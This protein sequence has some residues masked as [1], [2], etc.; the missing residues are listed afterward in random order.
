MLC[1]H[2]ILNQLDD[3]DNQIRGVVPVKQVVDI[4]LVHLL[5]ASIHLFAERRQQHNRTI[6]QNSLCLFRKIPY[7][8]ASGTVNDQYQVKYTICIICIINQ[9]DRFPRRLCTHDSRRITQI[10]FQVLLC[11]LY[12]DTAIL[13]ECKTVVVIANQ[14][15]PPHALRHQ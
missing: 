2:S 3:R 14:Q 4:R 6:R 11:Y 10:Q 5:H 1:I 8:I 15:N 9:S 12:V 13:L 7:L